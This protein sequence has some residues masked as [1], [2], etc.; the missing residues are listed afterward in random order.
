LLLV[1]TPQAAK[2]AA[3]T[4]AT[5]PACT[6]TKLL[7]VFTMLG[8]NFSVPA[9]FPAAISVGVVDDC[10]NSITAGSVIT[11]FSNGDPPLNLKPLGDGS[12]TATWVPRNPTSN[13]VITATAALTV[14]STLKLA[15]TVQIMG[16]A[17]SNAQSPVVAS[18][19]VV[20]AASFAANAPI[21]AGALISIF[22]SN[23][24]D[25]QASASML[26]LPTQL[27]TT[28]AT[29]DGANV[30]LL[31]A[32]SG[33]VNGVVPFALQQ[34]VT[35]FLVVTR[36]NAI[37]VPEPIVIAS[38]EPAIFTVNGSGSGQGV[39]LG[40]LNGGAQVLADSNNPVSAG[41]YIVMYATGL[42]AVTPAVADGVAGPSSPLSVVSNPISLTIGGVNATITYAGL[43]PGFASLYQVDAI[44]PTVAPGSAVP[45]V[46]TVAGQ[47]SPVVTIAVK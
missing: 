19:G 8:A 43:A 2:P 27:G 29:I 11:T 15:G 34:N 35:H 32:S 42:G 5:T 18:G 33:Q 12:W 14:S 41:G 16:N 38:A 44:V 47:S 30:P 1:V 13:A 46:I 25:Q 20:N 28:S 21:P 3:K 26:P 24:A 36:D 31:Y 39:V 22:G 4:H 37:S 10:A 23:L 9:G 40:F 45:L 7:P 6:P 17:Q